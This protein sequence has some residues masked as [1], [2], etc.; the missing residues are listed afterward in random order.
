[1]KK[2][3]NILLPIFI[4]FAFTV[5]GSAQKRLVKVIYIGDSI[6]FGGWLED[7]N[8][9]APPVIASIYLQKQPG[10][11]SVAF[12]NQGHSGFTTVDFLPGGASFIAVEE[13]ANQFADKSGTLIFSIMLGTNDSAIKGT[14]GAPVAPAT[15]YNNLKSIIDKLLKDFPQSRVVLNLP[16]WYS[17]NTYNGAQYLQE[18]LDRLQSYFTSI[19]KLV[20][21][22]HHHVYL[23][24]TSAF[25]YFKNNYLTKL[26]PED[27]HRGVFYLHPNK[28]GAA[29]LGIL[30]AKAIYPVIKKQ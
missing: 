16:L 24:D 6:T 23:G 29:D 5:P 30:W 14:N 9:Q 3:K 25:D 1:M 13:A 15:Y 28:E 19:K 27:G 12:S 4:V 17:P 18:G 8:T 10:I 2:F 20:K 7:V 21:T 26:R 11:D 22:Y